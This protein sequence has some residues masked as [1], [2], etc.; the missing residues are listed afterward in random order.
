MTDETK[1]TDRCDFCMKEK[2][3]RFESF[4]VFFNIGFSYDI[5]EDCEQLTDE[6]KGKIIKS[7]CRY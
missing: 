3:V 4:K 6:Q 7:R 5:C 1:I 2:E